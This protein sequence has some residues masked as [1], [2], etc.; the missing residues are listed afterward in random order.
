MESKRE[1]DPVE[2]SKTDK[3]SRRSVV[4]FDHEVIDF[5]DD[6]SAQLVK[7]GIAHPPH[8]DY[9]IDPYELKAADSAFDR[10]LRSQFST[11][12]RR[13]DV[14]SDILEKIDQADEPQHQVEKDQKQTK[15]KLSELRELC[16][17][18]L[19]TSTKLEKQVTELS[20]KVNRLE[21]NNQVLFSVLDD[22]AKLR[23][24]MKLYETKLCVSE[25][26]VYNST[27]ELMNA[28]QS[29]IY[30]MCRK[31]MHVSEL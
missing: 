26:H 5:S 30:R 3:R 25:S 13:P 19:Y 2:E 31:C 17:K 7:L 8:K 20:Q 15:P 24:L 18:L 9:R 21:E 27:D 22:V 23:Q 1:I 28:K 10:R 29:K 4:N 16:S 14:E 11:W 6:V 12:S